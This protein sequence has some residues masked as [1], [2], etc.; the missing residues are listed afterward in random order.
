MKKSILY[1]LS[2]TLTFI[3]VNSVKAQ[4]IYDALR[5]SQNYYEGT[6]RSIGVGNAMTSLG[7]DL[8]AVTIN[9]AAAGIYR[10]SE[11]V[12]TPLLTFS[13]DRTNYLNNDTKINKTRFGL[14]NVG[15]VGVFDTGRKYG[16]KN[17]NLSISSNGVN[18][19][20]SRTSAS[21]REAVTSWLSSLA[22]GTNGIKGTSMDMPENDKYAPFYS[23]ASWKSVLAWNAFLLDTLPGTN[24]QY[25]AAN[26]NINGAAIELGGPIDQ[27][28]YRNITG[29]NSEI[30]FNISTNISDKVFLG[31]NIGVQNLYYSHYETYSETALDSK[32]FQTGF[33]SFTHTYSQTTAGAGF[34]IKAGIIYLP[35]KGLRLGA[36]IATPTWLYLND[37][38]EE[39]IETTHNIQNGH[40]SILSPLGE[41]SYRVNTPFRVNAGASYVFGKYGFISADYEFADYSMIE[42]IESNGSVGGFL[43]QNRDIQQQFKTTHNIRVGAEFKPIQPLSIRLGYNLYSSAEKNFD[44]TQHLASIGVGYK[45]KG[46]FFIDLAYQQQLN[47]I[48]EAYSLYS[49]YS[50]VPELEVPIMKNDYLKSKLLLSIGIRF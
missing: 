36:S 45:S 44:A 12:V 50:D 14:A 5:F 3:A 47:Y 9:P 29:Y 15:I 41:Y 13:H 32:D 28:F 1:I 39:K 20:N 27:S 8:G 7:G 22:T 38:W 11:F 31:L 25:V 33:K 19:Y 4:S 26:E 46:G 42:M 17:V 30:N 23:G 18:N 24:D 37:R 35:I 40:Y 21:G 49:N 2:I 16:I 34:N 6:A 48:K 43:N 10:Y